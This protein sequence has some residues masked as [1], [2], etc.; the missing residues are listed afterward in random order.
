MVENNGLVVQ[1]FTASVTLLKIFHLQSE[2]SNVCM[3]YISYISLYHQHNTW[4]ILGTQWA[5]SYLLEKISE[6]NVKITT[7]VADGSVQFSSVQSCS[8]VQ[9]CYPI[10][11][12]TPDLPVQSLDKL[13]TID[14]VMPS[15]LLIRCCPLLLPPSI[16][17]SIIIFSNKSVLRMRWPKY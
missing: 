9:L 16:F 4:H 14:S 13:K 5:F 15:N 2:D 3:T 8:R 10:D 12:N 11:Y 1:K 6:F 17:P 7:T